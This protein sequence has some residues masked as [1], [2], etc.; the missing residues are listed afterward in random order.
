[1]CRGQTD[2]KDQRF[3]ED[4]WG[5]LAKATWREIKEKQ[6]VEQQLSGED[7]IPEKG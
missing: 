2:S 7:P 3:T 5:R 6:G 4:S 1:V